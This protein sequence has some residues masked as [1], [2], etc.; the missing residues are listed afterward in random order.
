MKMKWKY[1]LPIVVN[2]ATPFC[3]LDWWGVFLESFDRVF[4]FVW[5][6]FS[7]YTFEFK[8]NNFDFHPWFNTTLIIIQIAVFYSL[9]CLLSVVIWWSHSHKRYS[10]GLKI[11]SVVL[12]IQWILPMT[13]FPLAALQSIIVSLI[14]PIPMS[15]IATFLLISHQIKNHTQ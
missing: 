15:S 5:G 14:I 12:I 13:I 8:L 6:S 2:I 3:Y 7:M 1:G 11:V 10:S 4:V 9:S